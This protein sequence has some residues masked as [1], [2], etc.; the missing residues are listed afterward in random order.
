MEAADQSDLIS[1]AESKNRD[2]NRNSLGKEGK[3]RGNTEI[4]QLSTG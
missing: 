1:A 3:K 4:V 2:K